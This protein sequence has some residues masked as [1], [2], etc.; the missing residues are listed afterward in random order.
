[1]ATS[2]RF[3]NL[4]H[5][6]TSSHIAGL[7]ST[8][9]LASIFIFYSWAKNLEMKFDANHRHRL[10]DV[11]RSAGV[12]DQ[13][14]EQDAQGFTSA[15]DEKITE[16]VRVTTPAP[17]VPAYESI[18]HS[19]SLARLPVC[20]FFHNPSASTL[21]GAP[22]AFSAFLRSYPSLPQVIVSG[23]LL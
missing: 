23:R 5:V 20:A 3:A 19:A 2:S 14:Q 17:V 22:H 15:L 18:D 8:R 16:S 6:P 7:S 21:G 10:T 4:F 11:M 9:I 1:M 13:Q 12:K